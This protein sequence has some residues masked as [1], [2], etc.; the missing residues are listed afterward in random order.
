MLSSFQQ[1]LFKASSDKSDLGQTHHD[2][3]RAIDAV[4]EGSA[5]D[6]CSYDNLVFKLVD[7]ALVDDGDELDDV[8]AVE[9]AKD[10][11]QEHLARLND[12]EDRGKNKRKKTFGG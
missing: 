9:R 8:G 6:A 12:D 4:V 3:I 7:P 11:V 1:H 5:D 2:E 10:H